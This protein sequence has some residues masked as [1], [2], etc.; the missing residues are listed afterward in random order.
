LAQRENCEVF[1]EDAAVCVAVT[2]LPDWTAGISIDHDPAESAV[3][4]A[5]SCL[6]SGSRQLELANASTRAPASALPEII[7]PLGAAWI[8]VM[9]GGT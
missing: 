4:A 7:V 8:E 9:A 2:P 3:A 6:P 1:I 5:S